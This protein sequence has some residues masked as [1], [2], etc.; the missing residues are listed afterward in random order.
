MSAAPASE[1]VGRLALLAP[2]LGDVLIV[3]DVQNDFLPAVR[4]LDVHGG[5]GQRA[6]DEMRAAGVTLAS[7]G[8][9]AH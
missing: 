8:Q 9:L 5:D 3:V 1:A 6:L 7:S 2:R 4:P